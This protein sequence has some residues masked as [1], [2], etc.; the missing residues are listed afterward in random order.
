MFFFCFF[1]IFIDVDEKLEYKCFCFIMGKLLK[2]NVVIS[3]RMVI[4]YIFL[5]SDLLVFI[6]FIWYVKS[7]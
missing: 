4:V 3:R 1:I 2:V 7:L 6:K 5:L